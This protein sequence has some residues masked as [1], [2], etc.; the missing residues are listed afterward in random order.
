MFKNE[1][2]YYRVEIRDPFLEKILNSKDFSIIE[3]QPDEM[4]STRVLFGMYPQ[5]KVKNNTLVG[6]ILALGDIKELIKQPTKIKDRCHKIK[7]KYYIDVNYEKDK[8]R[9]IFSFDGNPFSVNCYR[10]MPIQWSVIKTKRDRC[11]MVSDMILDCIP[12]SEPSSNLNNVSYLESWARKWLN[13]IFYG[14]AFDTAISKYIFNVGNNLFDDKIHSS[15]NDKVEILPITTYE[16]FPAFGA[17]DY[18]TDLGLGIFPEMTRETKNDCVYG[19]NSSTY[20]KTL[21]IG[22]R[23]SI[24]IT[25]IASKMYQKD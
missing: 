18:A 13:N 6:K 15:I 2:E 16:N 11:M 14:D 8:Y 17:T 10:F 20:I 22:V 9:I 5:Y 21:P 24:T 23:P 12:F 19:A 7:N 4:N 3:S 25:T 1:N